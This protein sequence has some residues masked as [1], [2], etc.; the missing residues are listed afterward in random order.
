MSEQDQVDGRGTPQVDGTGAP[1]FSIFV[2]NISFTT[3]DH[4]LSGAQ[5]KAL[6]NVP[7]DYEL[8]QVQGDHTVPIGNEQVVHLHN[9][10]HFRAIPAGTF[11]C[12]DF[13]T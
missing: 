10:D 1:T 5:I 12:N 8:F 2:N 3:H 6:A 7:A 4:E 11:G 13:T 9:N